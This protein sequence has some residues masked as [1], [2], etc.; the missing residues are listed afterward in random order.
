MNKLKRKQFK[1]QS[2]IGCLHLLERRKQFRRVR[3][4]VAAFVCCFLSI[5]LTWPVMAQEKVADQQ[6]LPTPERGELSLAPAKVAV[7]PLA[8]DEQIRERLQSVMDT[9]GWFIKPHVEVVDGVVVLSPCLTRRKRLRRE[10]AHLTPR[11]DLHFKQDWRRCPTK[12]KLGYP[13]RL[14]FLKNKFVKPSP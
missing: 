14:L 12:Q 10:L 3:V 2:T 5:A 6:T 8:Q 11:T 4:L 1:Q 13:T 9:T 7:E